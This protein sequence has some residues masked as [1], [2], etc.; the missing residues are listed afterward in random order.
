MNDRIERLRSDAA[1]LKVGAAAARDGLW[2]AAGA[3]AM[4]GVVGVLAYRLSL[5]KDDHR[6]TSSHW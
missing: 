4:G 3:V 1:E 6:A 2:Q 5:G